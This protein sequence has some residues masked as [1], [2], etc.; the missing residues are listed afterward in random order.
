M[1]CLA[2][3]FESEERL[4]L[5]HLPADVG[6]RLVSEHRALAAA[7]YPRARVMAHAAREMQ[8]FRRHCPAHLVQQIEREHASYENR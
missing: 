6:A 5:P 4:C 2:C 8:W 1:D 7:G 3:H